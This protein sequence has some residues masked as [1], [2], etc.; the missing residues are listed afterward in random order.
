M[1]KAYQAVTDSIVERLNAGVIPWRQSWVTGIPCSMRSGKEYR[2][3]NCLI[4]GCREHLSKYWITYREAERLGGYVR[5]GEKG[6]P[7]IFWHWR[8]KE[9]QERLILE[10]KATNPAPCTP[11]LYRVFNYDQTEGVTL[12]TNDLGIEKKAPLAAAEEI[13]FQIGNRPMIN[14]GISRTPSYCPQVDVVQMPHLSQFE[15]AEQYYSTL[16]HELVHSTGHSSRLDRELVPAKSDTWELYCYEELVAEIGAAILCG[17][18]GISD[19]RIIEDQAAYIAHWKEYITTDSKGFI[20]ACC[21]AQRAVDFIR[22][23]D[24]RAN[25]VAEADEQSS[26]IEQ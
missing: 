17:V 5:K 23:L 13:V 15:S 21:E 7:I 1:N 16:F 26:T 3:I 10:G 8:S 20:K 22:G 14:H 9:E 25:D 4:L 6:T 2:G 19:E 11:F 12:Q 18:A 24:F